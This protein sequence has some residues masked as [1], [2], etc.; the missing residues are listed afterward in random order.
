[1]ITTDEY[2]DYDRRADEIF[3]LIN[4]GMTRDQVAKKFNYENIRSM[5][6]LMRRRGYRIVKNKYVKASKEKPSICKLPL[7]TEKLMDA[8]NKSVKDGTEISEANLN[9]WGFENRQQLNDHMKAEGVKFD[10]LNKRYYIVPK[11]MDDSAIS[12]ESDFGPCFV[13][14]KLAMLKEENRREAEA[15]RRLAD[16]ENAS[17]VSPQANAGISSSLQTSAGSNGAVQTS[18]N[19]NGAVPS[20]VSTNGAFQTSFN[21]NSS[22]QSS[23]STSGA[24]SSSLNNNGII[25]PTVMSS[26][27]IHSQFH[28]GGNVPSPAINNSSAGSQPSAN[29]QM[30]TNVQTSTNAKMSSNAQPSQNPSY[31]SN[32]NNTRAV[33]G[34]YD[35]SGLGEQSDTPEKMEDFLPFIHFLYNNKNIFDYMVNLKNQGKPFTINIPGKCVQKT[36]HINYNLACLINRFADEHGMKYKQVIEAAVVEYLNK[37]G[38][39][40]DLYDIINR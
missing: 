37:F 5:D 40:D 6:Q 26:G 12:H 1:M 33:A 11:G 14:E 35:T 34:T 27:T 22:L 18:F 13:D 28:G 17:Q 20:S 10:P 16:G 38:Y 36:F 23:V 29:A 21:N 3:E 39:G 15:K 25:K 30:S 2:I 31:F 24:A 32:K 7:R 9:R 4:N 8:L 19:N